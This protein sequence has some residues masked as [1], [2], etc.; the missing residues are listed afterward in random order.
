MKTLNILFYEFA[1]TQ[2]YYSS[3]ASRTQTSYRDISI[4]AYF[5]FREINQWVDNV[6]FVNER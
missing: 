2:S 1:E 5:N 6:V 3:L 4:F